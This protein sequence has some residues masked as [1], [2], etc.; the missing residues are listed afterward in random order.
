M[1]LVEITSEMT[2]GELLVGIGTLALAAFTAW[3]AWRTSAEVTASEEQIRV[4][5]ESIEAQDRPF[6][7]VKGN[8]AIR[9]RIAFVQPLFM[10]AI[11][12][13]GK[14]AAIV[15]EVTLVTE[16]GTNLLDPSLE[17]V[18]VLPAGESRNLRMPSANG[19]PGAGTILVLK[20]WYQSAS[21]ARYLTESELEVIEKG[22]C[23]ARGHRRIDAA[24]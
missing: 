21:G 2:A 16:G 10:F 3:L 18:P 7:V 17:A 6:V 24:A 12:N 15:E 23:K 4:S 11:D 5:R 13:V 20:I 9:H 14:G 1:G 8:S 19:T 22:S